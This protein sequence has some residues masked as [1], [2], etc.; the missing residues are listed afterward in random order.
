MIIFGVCDDDSS[1]V[2]VLST[3]IRKQ[4]MSFPD[5]VECEVI[6]FTNAHQVIDYLG[7]F[8]IHIL[9]LDIDMPRINGFELAKHIQKKAPST[10]VVFVSAYEK[11]VYDAFEYT[12]FCFLRKNHIKKELPDILKK[13]ISKITSSN[14]TITFNSQ[15]GII[16]VLIN[17]ISYIESTG[18]YFEVHFYDKRKPYRCRGTLSSVEKNLDQNHFYRIHPA[19][20]INLE[21]IKAVNAKREVIMLEGHI[22]TVSVRKWK[23]FNEAYMEFCRKKVLL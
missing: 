14:E 12:P 19:F 22:F 16:T 23:G 18:N 7:K 11:F 10:I 1:F 2:K 8:P 6:P 15:D 5:D 3:F 21:N 20:I 9:L 13:I 4:A 17:D